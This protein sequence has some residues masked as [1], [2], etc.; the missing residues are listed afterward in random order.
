VPK[1]QQLVSEH[2]LARVTTTTTKFEVEKFSGKEVSVV[3]DA[4]DVAARTGG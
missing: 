1:S 2:W 4:G 3:E